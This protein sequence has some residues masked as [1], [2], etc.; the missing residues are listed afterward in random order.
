MGDNRV[1]WVKKHIKDISDDEGTIRFGI[2]CEFCRTE[3]RTMPKKLNPL[4]ETRD[5]V[6]A[7]EYEQGVED[8]SSILMEC[9]KCGRF[10]CDRCA[11]IDE[12][13]ELCADCADCAPR[14]ARD[15]RD[16]RDAHDARDAHGRVV[17]TN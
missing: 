8:L 13:G 14:D 16:V 17:N 4:T 9:P 6:F 10:I 2:D 15:V 12:R 5:V 11:I 3:Y 1:K 7:E